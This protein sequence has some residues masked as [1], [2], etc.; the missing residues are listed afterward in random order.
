MGGLLNYILNVMSDV[1]EGRNKSQNY[2]SAFNKWTRSWFKFMARREPK[3]GH[4]MIGERRQLNM[5]HRQKIIQRS[6]FNYTLTCGLISSE[7]EQLNAGD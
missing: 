7:T 1:C 6:C 4:F 5:K 3:T 2:H